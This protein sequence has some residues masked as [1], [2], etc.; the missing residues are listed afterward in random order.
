[1]RPSSFNAGSLEDAVEFIPA[2]GGTPANVAASVA[3]LG[4]L[5]EVANIVGIALVEG[6][7]ATR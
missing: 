6:C 3:R 5:A 1:M 4:V 7:C 2:A